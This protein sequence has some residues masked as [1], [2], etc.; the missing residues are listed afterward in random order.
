MKNILIGPEIGRMEG[1]HLVHFMDSFLDIPSRRRFSAS[2][3][4]FKR[5]LD[6]GRVTVGNPSHCLGGALSD[7]RP[8]QARLF[9]VGPTLEQ[10]P[11]NS[12]WLRKLTQ[13]KPG[14]FRW[15]SGT[16]PRIGTFPKAG[17]VQCVDFNTLWRFHHFE[18]DQMVRLRPFATSP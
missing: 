11:F 15:V 8:V 6:T 14:A 16:S 4:S 17:A 13:G 9:N 2:S 1:F 12:R 7:A 5:A 10:R 3:F 18:T